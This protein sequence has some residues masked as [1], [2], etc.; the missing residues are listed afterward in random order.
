MP[1]RSIVHVVPGLDTGGAEMM[2]FKLL[3]KT[4]RD[5]WQPA[6]VSLRDRGTLG[7]RIEGLDIRVA[8]VGMRRSVPGVRDVWRLRCT[9]AG[10]T[11]S[12]IHGWMYHGNLAALV[13]RALLW[14]W[15]P[16]VW[17]VR[18]LV[19]D[20]ASE[21]R[22]TATIVRLGALLSSGAVRIVYNSRASARQHAEV[23]FPKEGAVVIPN[24]F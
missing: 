5:R 22:L 10:L 20:F 4:D 14:R 8:T 23:G 21:K 18:S 6:L 11:P 9:L 19:F 16:V 2:R 24:G 7:D 1:P 17:C 13:G 3:G 15:P 12:L